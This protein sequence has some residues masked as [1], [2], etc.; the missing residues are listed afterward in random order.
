MH[1]RYT[2]LGGLIL[3]SYRYLEPALAVDCD[4]GPGRAGSRAT[5]SEMSGSEPCREAFVK[6]WFLTDY[7]GSFT[8][9]DSADDI[10]APSF[11]AEIRFSATLYRS[12]SHSSAPPR[13]PSIRLMSASWNRCT[14]T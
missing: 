10:A 13:L 14:A 4:E 5:L 12:L 8:W 2:D 3:V 11:G 1:S 9:A 7:V 6:Y